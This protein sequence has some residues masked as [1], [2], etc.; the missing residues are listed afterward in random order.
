MHQAL[1]TYRSYKSPSRQQTY[2]VIA[3]IAFIQITLLVTFIMHTLMIPPDSA[4]HLEFAMQVLS[5][6]MPYKDIVDMVSP[7][8][9]YLNIIPA[10]ISKLIHIHPITVFNISVWVL[11][12]VSQALACSIVLKSH[13]REKYLLCCILIANSAM[14][15]FFISE[16][17]QIEHLFLLFTVPYFLSRYLRWSGKKPPQGL[18]M[19]SGVLAG[20]GFSLCPIFVIFFLGIEICFWLEKQKFDAFTGGEF[21]AC[22]AIQFIYVAHLIIL[23][24]SMAQNYLG[25]I[26]PLSILDWWQW[27]DRLL[28]VEKTP[29]R[30]D[31][32]Y[33]TALAITAGLALSRKAKVL[34]P[35]LVFTM[36]GIAT[37]L[38]QG[39]MFTFQAMPMIWGAGFCLIVLVAIALTLLP[40]LIKLAAPQY[41]GTLALILC[42]IFLYKQYLPV[43][44]CERL[45]LKPQDYWGTAPRCDLS[46]LS[47][48]VEHETKAGDEVLIINDRVRPA[49]PLILQLGLKPVGP[50]LDYAPNLI[51]DVFCQ[52]YSDE[53]IK[54]YCYFDNLTWDELA[55][56][57]KTRPPKLVLLDNESME[58]LLVKHTVRD[59]LNKSYPPPGYAD[60]K[61]HADKHPKYEHLSFHF[62]IA[63]FTRDH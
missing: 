52:R 60:W 2:A 50:M 48:F 3:V 35:C 26:L 57:I 62:P 47:E 15:L 28:Y 32:I 58:P 41:L 53:A 61:D 10:Y 49:Y 44:K 23:P 36:L 5:G 43:S 4:K 7:M 1:T 21:A 30:R 20:I 19:T 56:I 29:D 63:A 24:D 33:I 31:L 11:S 46:I 38:I 55:V 51:Y 12:C 34:A 9:L 54:K 25:W 27:D 22:C 6:K 18:S 8:M 40:Q 59:M 39:K 45:D 13:V 16:F 14:Q 37:Y 17:G 42:A